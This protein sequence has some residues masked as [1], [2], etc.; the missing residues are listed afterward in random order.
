MIIKYKTCLFL[1]KVDNRF[2][3]KLL[4]KFFKNNKKFYYRNIFI[5]ILYTI[6]YYIRISI[7]EN[8]K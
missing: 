8:L 6:I 5:F 7:F 1:Y 3:K 2:F 4:L